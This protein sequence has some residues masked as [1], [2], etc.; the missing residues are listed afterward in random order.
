M[1]TI[2][3]ECLL[4]LTRFTMA[5]N[6]ADQEVK[7]RLLAA[8]IASFDGSVCISFPPPPIFHIRVVSS[9]GVA[10]AKSWRLTP[11]SPSR[12][13]FP[14]TLYIFSMTL[15]PLIPHVSDRAL[16]PA[17]SI[18][19]IA[20]RSHDSTVEMLPTMPLKTSCASLRPRPRS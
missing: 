7:D 16:A 6:W 18:R 15:A 5:I 14:G 2:T 9:T 1:N 17:D 3:L 13:L 8:I 11:S 12:P 10:T 20:A 19:S 4:T